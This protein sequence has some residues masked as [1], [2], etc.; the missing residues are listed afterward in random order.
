MGGIPVPYR[1]GSDRFCQYEDDVEWQ[2]GNCK[3]TRH[4]GPVRMGD[5][6]S[7]VSDYGPNGAEVEHVGELA[8]VTYGQDGFLDSVTLW[9]EDGNGKLVSVFADGV[10]Y[11]P[12]GQ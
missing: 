8:G 9:D 7:V 5:M 6:V 2:D 11:K 1:L 3:V 4:E 12:K 10:F